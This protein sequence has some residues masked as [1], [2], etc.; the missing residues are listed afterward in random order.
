MQAVHR[1]VVTTEKEFV[2]VSVHTGRST[3]GIHKIDG[4]KYKQVEYSGSN[5][6]LVV[7]QQ[8]YPLF[9][10]QNNNY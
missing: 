4:H 1:M 10:L 2:L 5:N 8:C 3:G 6:L 7:R 9:I